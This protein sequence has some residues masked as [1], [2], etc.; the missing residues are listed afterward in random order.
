MFVFWYL[1]VLIELKQLINCFATQSLHSPNRA[2]THYLD[3]LATFQLALLGTRGACFLLHCYLLH[4]SPTVVKEILD[5]RLASVDS[6]PAALVLECLPYVRRC[7][8]RG[9][10]FTDIAQ[11]QWLQLFRTYY[12]HYGQFVCIDVVAVNTN[13]K[14]S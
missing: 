12:I 4:T 13:L 5:L 6:R 8:V 2:G 14:I 7:R 11:L 1:R 9:V 10:N 3:L